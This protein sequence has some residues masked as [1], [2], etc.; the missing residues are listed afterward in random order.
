MTRMRALSYVG[1]WVLLTAYYVAFERE[2]DAVE[3]MPEQQPPFLELA[4]DQVVAVEVE[5]GGRRLSSRRSGQ[6]WEVVAPQGVPVFDDLIDAFLSTLTDSPT[7]EVIGSRVASAEDFGL[8][9]PTARIIL[10]L[11]DAEPVSVLLGRRNPAQTAIY[12]QRQGVPTI[13]L[14]GLNVQYY[15]ELLMEG[16]PD[17]AS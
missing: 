1:V 14:L 5:I 11:A 17:S 16:V 12:A 15:V 9:D 8:E 13:V 7:V 4:P 6:G 2:S 3:V 10:R